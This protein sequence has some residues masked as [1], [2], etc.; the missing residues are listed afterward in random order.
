MVCTRREIDPA[1]TSYLCAYGRV[2][3]A[4]NRR[5]LAAEVFDHWIKSDPAN[6]MAQHLANA[7]LGAQTE[8]KVP[9]EYIRALFDRCAN[10]FDDYLAK[11]RYRGP[12]LILEALRPVLSESTS[13]PDILDAGC[14]TGLVGVQLRP[15]ARQLIGV[16]L[17]PRM[18]DEARQRNI[19]DELVEDDMLVYL[20]GQQCRFDM[21]AAADVLPYLGD[22]SELFNRVA[23]A[24]ALAV[25]SSFC[26]RLL[27]VTSTSD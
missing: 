14:G 10:R 17:S 18:L 24:C 3:V 25:S 19:Y 11:L 15:H 7:A 6:P 16:D 23:R 4:L 26:W 20:R 21:V 22:L 9:T 1:D 5:A 12:D 8:T 2:L 27:W 13:K